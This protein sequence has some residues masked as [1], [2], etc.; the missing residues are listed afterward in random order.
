MKAKFTIEI[1]ASKDEIDSFTKNINKFVYRNNDF[2]MDVKPIGGYVPRFYLP[3]RK[4]RMNFK[5]EMNNANSTKSTR[6]NT[7]VS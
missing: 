1:E 2:L 4:R 6:K 5:K 3:I 7:K